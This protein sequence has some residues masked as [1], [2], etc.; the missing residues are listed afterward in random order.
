MAR[1]HP[2]A[3]HDTGYQAP[4]CTCGHIEGQHVLAGGFLSMR[5]GVCILCDCKNFTL[6]PSRCVTD[7]AGRSADQRDPASGSPSQDAGSCCSDEIDRRFAPEIQRD[8]Q[9][10]RDAA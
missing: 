6:A 7:D 2:T 4:L 3:V 1:N 9:A 5:A 8:D 10:R